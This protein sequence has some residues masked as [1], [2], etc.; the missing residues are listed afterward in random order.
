[1]KLILNNTYRQ[2]NRHYDKKHNV[3]N[4]EP[5]K[6]SSNNSSNDISFTSAEKFS[7]ILSKKTGEVIYTNASSIINNLDKTFGE[8]FFS[9]LLEKA[10]IS[11]TDNKLAI[12]NTG[13]FRR[14]IDGAKQ[15]GIREALSIIGNSISDIP[16]KI[17]VPVF[18]RLSDSKASS[19]ERLRGYSKKILSSGFFANK[20]EKFEIRRSYETLTDILEELTSKKLALNPDE[21]LQKSFNLL[22]CTEYIKNKA[23]SGVTQQFKNYKTRDERTINR[24]VTGIVSSIFG[25]IDFYNLSMVQK[26]NKK[27]AEKAGKKRFF[28]ELKNYATSAGFTFLTLGALNKYIKD[29]MALNVLAII[30]STI[31]SQVFSKVTSGIPIIPLTPEKAK[32]IAQKRKANPNSNSNLNLS[33]NKAKTKNIPLKGHKELIPKEKQVFGKFISKDGSFASLNALNNQY[34]MQ[35]K[36]APKKKSNIGKILGF[37]VA[38]ASIVYLISSFAKGEFKLKKDIKEIYD[39]NADKIKQFLNGEVEKLDDDVLKQ[40]VEKTKEQANRAEKFHIIS[41]IKKS[42]VF[43]SKNGTSPFSKKLDL[44]KLKT[45]LEELKGTEKGRKIEDILNKYI[46]EIDSILPDGETLIIEKKNTILSGLYSGLTKLPKTIYQIFSIPGL[47]IKKLLDLAV[48]K[49]SNSALEKINAI[50]GNGKNIQKEL[51]KLNGIIFKKDKKTG[52]LLEN[53]DIIDEISKKVR[54]LSVGPETSEL[55]NYARTCVTVISSLFFI[56]DYRNQVLIESEGRDTKKAS[57]E[58]G[59]RIS[60]KISNFIING[61]LMN[62]FNSTFNKQLNASLFGAAWVPTLTELSNEFL[63]RKSIFQPITP[64]GS[65]Q[66]IIDFEAEQNSRK[67]LI[68]WWNKTYKK[69]TNKK[70]LT[71]KAGINKSS[72]SK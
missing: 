29:S 65:K 69:L 30:G 25:G 16:A 33:F 35:S 19:L 60:Q 39:K 8:K 53:S 61:T 27:E 48:Y 1:M 62:L 5:L 71:E 54:K 66:E 51:S 28:V 68:G 23:S 70:S 14:I 46:K 13:F 55:A 59:T 52:K 57:E 47:G 41:R 15:K 12:K 17:L 43:Y 20:K 42:P 6:F 45:R 3:V 50:S 31:I 21:K 32:A 44:I 36:K 22:N 10:C 7:K 37:G 2:F 11:V 24:L 56:N 67:G 38:A 49:D 26:D 18:D 58:V 34:S 4:F 72:S 40:I 63:T 64:M 9:S